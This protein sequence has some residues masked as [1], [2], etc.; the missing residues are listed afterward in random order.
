MTI[1]HPAGFQIIAV[2]ATAD[3]SHKPGLLLD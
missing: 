3:P 1:A 2:P